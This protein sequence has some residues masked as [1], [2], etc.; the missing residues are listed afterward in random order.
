MYFQG[1]FGTH[2]FYRNYIGISQ[3]LYRHFTGHF[4]FS[5]EKHKNGKES[6]VPKGGLTILGFVLVQEKAKMKK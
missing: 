5:H 4:L 6:G 2:E 1:L 3:E